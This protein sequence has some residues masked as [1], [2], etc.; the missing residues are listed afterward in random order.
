MSK[1]KDALYMGYLMFIMPF[2]GFILRMAFG[3]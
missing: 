3:R 2:I 1:H